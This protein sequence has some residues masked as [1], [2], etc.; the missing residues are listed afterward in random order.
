MRK[1]N[2]NSLI[3]TSCNT[4]TLIAQIGTVIACSSFV[5][6]CVNPAQSNRLTNVAPYKVNTN[7]AQGVINQAPF[8]II[9]KKTEVV[10]IPTIQEQ[11][12]VIGVYAAGVTNSIAFLT[13]ETKN[14]IAKIGDKVLEG[15]ITQIL[16]SGVVINDG[17]QDVT[18]EISDSAT[19]SGGGGNSSTTPSSS[20]RMGME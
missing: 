11:V 6:W 19:P 14:I 10:N 1:I 20:R 18:I 9:V 16:P 4:G 13:V 12:K 3:T 8:G 17:K 2:I 7:I 5:W 15:T